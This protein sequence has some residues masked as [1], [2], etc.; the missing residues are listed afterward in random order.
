MPEVPEAI[1]ESFDVLIVGAG[2]SGIGAAVH[3]QRR[4]PSKT[5]A[6]LEARGAIGGTWD[7]FKFPGVRSDSDMYTLGYSFR[8]WTHAHAIAQGESI[9]RY[10]VDAAREAGVD[11]HIRFGAR[12]TKA[13]WS[14][15]AAR[16]TIEA[17]RSDHTSVRLSCRFLYLCSGYYDYGSAY[18]PE[19]ANEGSFKGTMVHPQFWPEQLD[20]AGKQVIVIGS[21]ATAVTLIP[22]MA[23]RAAHVTM[24]QRSPSYVFNLPTVDAMAATLRRFLPAR[25]AYPLLRTKNVLISMAIFQF[26]R[27]WPALA[28]Q[29]LIRM[30][31]ERLPANFDIDRHFTPRYNVWDQRVCAVT[32]GDL[33]EAIASG[34]VTVVTDEIDAFT[35]YGILLKSGAH[36]AADVVVVATGLKLNLLGDI[37][38]TV[39]GAQVGMS[40]AM[41]Y[42][43]A[44]LSGVPNMAYSF[45]YTN[46]SWT[47]KA[48]LTANYVCRLLRH[49]DSHGYAIAM[50]RP[51]PAL[52]EQPFLDFTSGYV[53]RA[54][55]ILPKQGSRRPWKVYQNYFLD[56]LAL[57]CA[58]IDDGVLD[59]ER[60]QARPA[61]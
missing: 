20:Y 1:L 55:S 41:A 33:F 56:T 17:R 6:I 15:G 10:I 12:V 61:A 21:G 42:K 7:L 13:A 59:F 39:N 30:V 24:L 32:D 43:G 47:L 58:R 40:G 14:S 26:A 60:A 2:L 35:G 3:L 45:G 25:A 50:P 49:M 16:W 8:P 53:A 54:L 34:A 38:F 27:R 37:E 9:R 22:E 36:L 18:R 48:D 11:A 51:D 23:K 29:R 19:F 57:R 5:Y 4:C 31:R 46:A 28:K 44:M 52:G